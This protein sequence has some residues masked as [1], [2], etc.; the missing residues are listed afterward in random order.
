VST[1][2]FNPNHILNKFYGKTIFKMVLG[3]LPVEKKHRRNGT[4]AQKAESYMMKRFI[5]GI[6]MICWE[7]TTSLPYIDGRTAFFAG[8]MMILNFK[9]KLEQLKMPK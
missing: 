5:D 7:C 6:P 3:W 9:H 1:K 8:L 4:C 2:T